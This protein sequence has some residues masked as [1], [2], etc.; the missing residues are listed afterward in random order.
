MNHFHRFIGEFVR[1]YL[2]RRSVKNI[3]EN[4][5]KY[6][7]LFNLLYEWWYTPLYIE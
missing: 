2:I 7:F 1:T 4:E 6:Y 3:K 5:I